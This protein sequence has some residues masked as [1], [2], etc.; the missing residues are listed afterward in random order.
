MK[1]IYD[2]V[3][4]DYRKEDEGSGSSTGETVFGAVT[5]W[6][7]TA[8]AALNTEWFTIRSCVRM[9]GNNVVV[10]W[11][12]GSKTAL[13]SSG[14]EEDLR[15]WES[16]GEVAYKLTHTYKEPGTYIVT[17]SGSDYFGI[18][19]GYGYNWPDEDQNK[20]GITHQ[21]LLS[22]CLD[23]DLSVAD[24][25]NNLSYF[26]AYCPNLKRVHI[27]T[28]MELTRIE[29]WYSAFAFCPDLETATGFLYKLQYTKQAGCLFRGDTALVTSDIKFPNV[30]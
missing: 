22:R 6:E 27:P 30:F 25:V 2:P 12:D 11:G 10:H 4:Q 23:I 1:A 21:G 9:A 18:S 28:Q 3:L 5:K 24:C 26:A 15:E 16:D 8:T 14:I 29:N 7:V 13:N 17:I 20:V 19:R